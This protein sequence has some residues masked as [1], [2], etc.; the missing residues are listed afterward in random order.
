M[1]FLSDNGAVSA[2]GPLL[3]VS[4]TP[5]FTSAAPAAIH[6]LLPLHAS[7]APATIHQPPHQL[8]GQGVGIGDE[9]PPP[10]LMDD[11]SKLK[12]RKYHDTE[13]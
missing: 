5:G 13:K 4:G 3:S 9:E 12:N 2:A 11:L 6:Q 1:G 7:A 8:R 10:D